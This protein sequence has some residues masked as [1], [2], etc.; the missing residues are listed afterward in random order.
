MSIPLKKIPALFD[1]GVLTT[2]Q[3][4]EMSTAGCGLK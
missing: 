3:M 2:E 1:A 4:E